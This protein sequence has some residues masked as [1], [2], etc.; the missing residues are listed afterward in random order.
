MNPEISKLW[1]IVATGPHTVHDLRAFH[2]QNKSQLKRKV[3]H[4]SEFSS[5]DE[6]K[7]VVEDTALAWNKE[8]FNVYITINPIRHD[9]SGASAKDTDIN[10]R[11]LL[12]IDIDRKGDTKQPATEQ[13]IQNAKDLA[14]KVMAYLSVLGW[15][16][17]TRMMSGNGHHLYYV[18]DALPNNDE[19]TSLVTKM[20]KTLADKFD[21]DHVRIDTSVANASRIT[22]V[23]GTIMRKGEESPDRPY[24]MAVVL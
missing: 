10:Y 14:D 12:F 7:R 6:A 15:P 13:D 18:L 19:S 4:F 21:N 8:G 17:P 11:D 1:E 22:K 2:H 16:T 24:R 3:F 9:F 20:L 5:L 23:P